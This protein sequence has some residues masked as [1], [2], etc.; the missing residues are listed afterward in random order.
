MLQLKRRVGHGSLMCCQPTKLR[1][2]GRGRSAQCHGAEHMTLDSL[3]KK[4]MD[5]REMV[6][7]FIRMVN[8]GMG[9]DLVF[10]SYGLWIG[11]GSK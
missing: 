10:E 1:Q 8:K 11:L 3:Q 6:S 7:G 9:L 5:L 4:M 2:E